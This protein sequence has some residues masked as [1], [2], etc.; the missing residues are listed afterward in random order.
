MVGEAA[1]AAGA[2]AVAMPTPVLLAALARSLVE[3]SERLVHP[4]E[5]RLASVRDVFRALSRHAEEALPES[6]DL[7]LV[8]SSFERLLA[9]G[10]GAVR[11]RSTFEA[12]GSLQ[13]VVSDLC[14]RTE[15]SWGRAG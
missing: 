7:D 3:T 13:A 10:N 6:G 14:D 1:R 5:Q 15:A 9:R 12:T 8:E 4:V 11:Q 2:V